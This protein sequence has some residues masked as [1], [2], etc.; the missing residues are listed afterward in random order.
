M[1]SRPWIGSCGAVVSSGS[2]TSG[3]RTIPPFLGL[4]FTLSL[5][6][7][8]CP[9]EI[10]SSRRFRGFLS[11]LRLGLSKLFRYATPLFV[12]VVTILRLYVVVIH[13]KR[14]ERENKQTRGCTGLQSPMSLHCFVFKQIVLLDVECN[15]QLISLKRKIGER[16]VPNLADRVMIGCV[17]L[18]R[19]PRQDTTWE[20]RSIC[21][22]GTKTSGCSSGSRRRRTT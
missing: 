12:S 11:F 15:S 20:L 19:P 10:R 18:E 22:V 1:C 9:I 14:K 2:A 8:S 5:S 4:C 13:C 17:L 7:V 3:S 16:D 6:G 21:T